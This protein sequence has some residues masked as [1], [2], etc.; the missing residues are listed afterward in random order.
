MHARRGAFPEAVSDFA[1]AA[2]L[3]PGDPTAAADLGIALHRAGRNDDAERQLRR[4]LRRFGPTPNVTGELGELL[5]SQGRLPEARDLL[6]QA[7]AQ[8]RRDLASALA[9]AGGPPP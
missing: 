7:V 3:A 2:R 6:A 9:A 1:E 5:L 4:T 8:G